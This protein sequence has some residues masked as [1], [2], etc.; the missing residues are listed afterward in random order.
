MNVSIDHPTDKA[1]FSRVWVGDLTLIFSYTTIIA[2]QYGWG[3]DAW[4]V[5][6][7]DWSNTTGKHLNW[8]SEDKSSRLPS[9]EFKA[10]LD[11]V[12]VVTNLKDRV[13]IDAI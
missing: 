5:R 11:R 13:D 8:V 10:A 2:F 7:N 9:D 1:N 3:A 6:E 4:V 12:L